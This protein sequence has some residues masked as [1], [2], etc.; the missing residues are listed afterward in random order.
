MLNQNKVFQII[1]ELEDVSYKTPEINKMV[2]TRERNI[3]SSKL[4]L[5]NVG[6]NLKTLDDNLN[7]IAIKIVRGKNYNIDKQLDIMTEDLKEKLDKIN[8]SKL[9]KIVILNIFVYVFNFIIWTIF[10]I[11]FKR[12]GVKSPKTL[13]TII[14]GFIVS[15]IT[16]ELAAKISEKGK[17]EQGFFSKVGSKIVM[18]IIHKLFLISGTVAGN[19]LIVSL[20]GMV[21]NKLKWLFSE[22]LDNVVI[23]KI[24]MSIRSITYYC[25]IVVFKIIEKLGVLIPGGGIK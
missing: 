18:T 16:D 3:E 14:T 21:L 13:A 7:D 12:F 8:N 22:E 20:V 24:V 1:T 10:E 4:V 23:E 5:K 19:Q 9:V 17:Y 6:I 15:P 2:K 11:T 25:Y